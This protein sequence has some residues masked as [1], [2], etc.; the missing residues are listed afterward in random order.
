MTYEQKL[1]ENKR[2]LEQFVAFL[3]ECSSYDERLKLSSEIGRL[4]DQNRQI[5]KMEYQ[6][7]KKDMMDSRL[8]VPAVMPEIDSKAKRQNPV[9]P[10]PTYKPKQLSYEN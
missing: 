1:R 7:A 2:L 3:G 9:K 6:E 10:L 4:N 8:E 5:E